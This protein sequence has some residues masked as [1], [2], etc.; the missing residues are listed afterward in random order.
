MVPGEWVMQGIQVQPGKSAAYAEVITF[1]KLIPDHRFKLRFS[2][3]Y[4]LCEVFVNGGSVGTHE[5]GFVPFEVDLTG[6]LKEGVNHL[7]ITVRSESLLDKLS[8]GSQYAMHS[9]GGITRKIQL[10]TVPDVH[11]SDLKVDTTFDEKFQ[12]AVLSARCEIMNQSTRPVE[13]MVLSGSVA[14]A[15]GEVACP[16]IEPGA[17]AV[18]TLKIPVTSPARWDCEHPNLHALNL[19]LDQGG[20]RMQ[21]LVETV[22]FRQVEIKGNTLLVNGKPVRLHGV[23]RH[24]AHPLLGR[25]LTPEQWKADARLFRDMNCNYIRTSH[26][27][28]AEEFIAECDK[29]GLFVELEAPLCWVKNDQTYLDPGA[30]PDSAVPDRLMLANLETIQGYPNHPSVLL[31][32]LANESKWS[33]HFAKVAQAVHEANPTRPISFHD[34]GGRAL[35]GY[36]P[37]VMIGNNHY[38]DFKQAAA[39]NPNCPLLYGE[40]CHLNAYNRLELATDPALR[41]TW[42]KYTRKMWDLIYQRPGILGQAIWS[43]IDDTFYLPNGD[44]VGYGSWGPIDGWRREKPEYWQAKKTYSPLRILNDAKPELKDRTVTLNIENRYIFSNLNEMKIAWTLGGQSGLA[45]ADIAPATQG[46]LVIKLEKDPQPGERLELTCTDPRGFVADRFSLPLLETAQTPPAQA[47]PEAPGKLTQTDG[48]FLASWPDGT[49]RINRKTGQLV[50]AG[51]TTLRGPQLMLLALKKSGETQMSGKPKE[52]KPFTEPCANWS[53]TKASAS[54][55]EGAVVVTLEGA[56]V[57]AQGAFTI[58][59]SSA[60]AAE[61]SY[62]FKTTKPINP[63]QIGLVFSLPRECEKLS[64]QRLGDWDVYPENDI[65]RLKGEVKASEGFAAESV[66]PRTKPSHPWRLD[67]LPYGNN[68]FCSTKHQ[69]LS[70]SVTDDSGRGILIDGGGKQHVRCWRT[71]QETHVLIADYSN[72]GSENFLRS[73]AQQDDHPLKAG[74]AVSGKVLIKLA[75]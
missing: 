38:P 75:K 45:T 53:C 57:G 8:S 61:I 35:A 52:W 26:Y 46:F 1:P 27:P 11:V 4:S 10:F 28:P 5:G 42:G 73:L 48:E 66:G 63:R 68:D 56:C 74:D 2:A 18:V 49:W 22:G 3:V 50:S 13:D 15:K 23:C 24:E 60:T 36:P 19:T 70:A 6:A 39:D 16:R 9:L 47:P 43:G 54:E 20:K 62:A 7:V 30:A 71:E 32:S 25:A 14:G 40:N 33:D 69:I 55:D 67:N 21:E 34:Y 37:H 12:D 72:G 41:E 65:A 51:K 17:S 31:R 64:W 29:L 59:L 58:R 44:T